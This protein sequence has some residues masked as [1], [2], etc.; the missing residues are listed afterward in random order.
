MTQL[1][2]QYYQNFMNIHEHQQRLF[3]R[4]LYCWSYRL[5]LSD[6]ANNR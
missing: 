6:A 5:D 4:I 1:H 2:V 3:V